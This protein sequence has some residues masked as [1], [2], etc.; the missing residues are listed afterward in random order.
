MEAWLDQIAVGQD[1]RNIGAI[2]RDRPSVVHLEGRT[3]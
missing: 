2:L 3:D 1:A